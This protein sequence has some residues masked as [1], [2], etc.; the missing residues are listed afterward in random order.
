[1]NEI[2]R[3]NV[4]VGGDHGQ[5]AFRFPMKLLFIM[6]SSKTFERKS[7]VIYI[8]YKR[9]Y[10]DIL[11]NTIIEKLQESF[12]LILDPIRFNNHQ[13]SIENLYVTSDLAFLIIL[14]GKEFSSAK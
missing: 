9:D 3:I 14:L 12:M 10:D 4:T 11:K 1:M 7:S 6:K 8:L 5:G 13:V 2:S